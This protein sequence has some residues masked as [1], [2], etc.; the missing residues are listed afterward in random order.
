MKKG[1]FMALVVIG[2]IVAFIVFIENFT[3]YEKKRARPAY[4]TSYGRIDGMPVYGPIRKT[5]K[6]ADHVYSFDDL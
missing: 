3:L 4:N 1:H 2:L 5:D 6:Y